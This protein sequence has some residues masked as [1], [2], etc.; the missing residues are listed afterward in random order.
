MT[1]ENNTVLYTG[2]TG[3][4]RRRVYEHREKMVGGFTKKY[5]A[6]KPVYHEAVEDTES[7]IPREKKIQGGSKTKKIEL[8]NSI[9]KAWRDLYEEI[10]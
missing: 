3:D 2:V 1:S 7:A 4:I 9:N 10:L 5:N 8:I 6:T